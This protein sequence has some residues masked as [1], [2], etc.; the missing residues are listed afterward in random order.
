MTAILNNPKPSK[1]H[2]SYS[3]TQYIQPLL[4]YFI[5]S[6]RVITWN[7][8]T[9][10]LWLEYQ[11]CTQHEKLLMLTMKFQHEVIQSR[12]RTHSVSYAG[13]HILYC[14]SAVEW[15]QK[16][17]LFEWLAVSASICVL[18]FCG[19]FKNSSLYLRNN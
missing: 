9:S 16:P 3:V 4:K 11:L 2:V 15:T 7:I 12:F 17:R 6:C 14:N 10:Y 8:C 18:C 5:R 13:M 1:D 19:S